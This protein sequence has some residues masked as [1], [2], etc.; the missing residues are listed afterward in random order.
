MSTCRTISQ[1]AR[2]SSA[3]IHTNNTI[4]TTTAH[5]HVQGNGRQS[6][7]AISSS[8]SSSTTHDS[9]VSSST[10]V[11]TSDY[12]N[13]EFSSMGLPTLQPP[14]PQ[15]S[16]AHLAIGTRVIVPS[17]CV[18]GTL[19]FLGETRFKPGTWAGIELDVEGAGKNDGS[20]QG[21]R[22]FTCSE[23]TGLFVPANKASPLP[24]GMEDDDLDVK[25][26]SARSPSRHH[27]QL[28][29]KQSTITTHATTSSTRAKHCCSGKRHN[30]TTTTTSATSSKHE[31]NAT[32]RKSKSSNTN[33]TTEASQQRSIASRRSIHPTS[34]KSTAMATVSKQQQ[35]PTMLRKS[36][37][38][39]ST[40]ST[41][42]ASPALRRASEGSVLRKS[43]V[44]HQRS[45]SSLSTRK[46][47][48]PNST[49]SSLPSAARPANNRRNSEGN[50]L[51]TTRKTSVPAASS[52]SKS[53]LTRRI[54]STD[55]TSSKSTATFNKPTASKSTTARS[56][57]S[58]RRSSAASSSVVPMK[59]SRSTTTRRTKHTVHK[60][61][62]NAEEE[63]ERL[64]RLLEETRREHE[65][66]CLE[67]SGKE[68]V[69]EQVVSSKESYAVQV[70]EQ[71]KEIDRLQRRIQALESEVSQQQQNVAASSKIEEYKHTIEQQQHRIERL[72]RHLQQ[73][74]AKQ[75][76]DQHARDVEQQQHRALVQQLRDALAERDQQT[77]YLENA[78]QDLKQA[79]ADV[80]RQW[81]LSTQALEEKHAK[82]LAEKDAHIATLTASLEEHKQQLMMPPPP[83]PS[84]ED[85][86]SVD[87]RRRLEHQLQLATTELDRERNEKHAKMAH[88]EQLTAQ[89]RQ[90]QHAAGDSH[91]QI[92]TLQQKLDAEVKDKRRIMDD[93]TTT[94]TKMARLQ[95]QHDQ[96]A[97]SKNRI[98]HDL[99]DA[100]RRANALETRIQQQAVDRSSSS[101]RHSLEAENAHL[102]QRLAELE[103]S[104]STL[105]RFSGGPQSPVSPVSLTSFSSLLATA[106]QQHEEQLYCEI[107]EVF[108]HDVMGCTAYLTTA[109]AGS[110]DAD[111]LMKNEPSSSYCV[112]CDAFGL[113]STE[114]CPNQ[115]EMF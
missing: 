32:M 95:D 99:A 87:R 51:R 54:S 16:T 40:K 101:S 44:P 76:D 62:A 12:S 112:N 3:A 5:H 77:A 109:P 79:E 94:M 28:Q 88:I 113:H 19:R 70:Q 107:C 49:K 9:L 82:A 53:T 35:R 85:H 27:H 61:Q 63:Q 111:H 33:V 91:Q 58:Q 10:S 31:P 67:M 34:S 43:S 81:R 98:E 30:T 2:P 66:L 57:E 102:L 105:R 83:L 29:Q 92:A 17:L 39:S 41:V 65:K 21:V 18:I 37:V 69:W 74:Q 45:S 4:T 78:Y 68:A 25:I 86:A 7:S 59:T 89:I 48:V 23:H 46:T 20:I 1:I 47:A 84:H 42:I 72:D 115:D 71:Q 6:S 114:D 110:D 97:M 106:T 96:M 73:L 52:T 55:V 22:Y 108:G 60:Q 38:P 36:S 50:T 14:A 75:S 100:I 64:K 93:A 8:S 13:D 90:M 11:S 56:N 80:R 104:S 15:A 24:S 103:K 26:D